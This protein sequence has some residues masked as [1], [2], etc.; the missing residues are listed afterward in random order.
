MTRY[1]YIISIFF[2]LLAS[3]ANRGQGPQGGPRDTISPVVLKEV[4]LNGTL[5]FTGKEVQVYFDEYIQLDDVANKVLISPPQQNPPEVKAI[6]KHL[7]VVFMEDLQDSTTYTIDFGSAIC[8]YNEK[9]PLTG[10]V[11]SFS[12]GDVIDS[13]SISGTIYDASYL[14]KCIYPPFFKLFKTYFVKLSNPLHVI[15][16]LLFLMSFVHQSPSDWNSLSNVA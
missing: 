13:L 6:G 8:D 11:F 15:Q 14:T 16:F 3:C 9:T 2:L 10:Y 4:P 1:I 12:T 7:S 5:L